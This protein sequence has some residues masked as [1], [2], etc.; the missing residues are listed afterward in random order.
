MKIKNKIKT[1]KKIARTQFLPRTKFSY[2]PHDGT[3][4]PM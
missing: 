3:N 4:A 2:S 1:P